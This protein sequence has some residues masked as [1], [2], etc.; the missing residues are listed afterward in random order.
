MKELKKKLK[1]YVKK[2]NTLYLPHIWD[3]WGVEPSKFTEVLCG[4]WGTFPNPR[5]VGNLLELDVQEEPKYYEVSD[6]YNRGNYIHK[7]ALWGYAYHNTRPNQHVSIYTHDRD[8]IQNFHKTGSVSCKGTT[9]GCERFFLELD[10]PTLEEAILDA[11]K[12]YKRIPYPEALRLWYSG[13]NSIHIEVDA[14]LFGRP[15]GKQHNIA[16]YGKLIYNLAHKLAGDVRNDIDVVD[17]WSYTGQELKELHEEHFGESA[18]HMPKHIL[19]QKFETIDP[20]VFGINSLIRQP[21]SVHEKKGMMKVPIDINELHLAGK[22]KFPKKKLDFNNNFPYLIHWVHDCYKKGRKPSSYDP[23]VDE[24]EVVKLFS[25]IFKY[26]DPRD[27]NGQGWV[28]GL[29]SPF[30]ED[31]NPSVSVNVKTG[32]YKDFG[33]PAHSLTFEQLKDKLNDES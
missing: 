8:W 16:G 1:N 9:A 27:S 29:Y 20:N 26:F 31:T 22:K 7:D 5:M 4:L 17:P 18:D 6:E 28:N 11:R 10:R 15:M 13:N 24:D 25:D 3:K 12:I 19:R 2:T 23:D 21:Y 32:Y 33:E 30:Y 14:T